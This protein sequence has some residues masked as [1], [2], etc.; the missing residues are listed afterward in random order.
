[1]G[2]LTLYAIK[3]SLTLA[4]LYLPYT[5]LMRRDTLFGFNR[6]A[7]IAIVG[8]SLVV[9]CLDLHIWDNSAIGLLEPQQET[10]RQITLPTFVV[11][12]PHSFPDEGE[13]A[14]QLL[15]VMEKAGRWLVLLYITGMLACL[16]WK[17]VGLVCL[18][19]FIPR[20]CLWI[21]EREDGIT[22]YCHAGQVAPFSWMHSIVIGEEHAAQGAV[23]EHELAHVRMGH[24]WDIVL[25]SL[26]ETLQWFNPCVWMLEASLREIHEYEADDA[27]LRRGVT[28]RDYQLLLIETAV[29]R[30]RYALVNSFNHSLLKN[31]IT[32]M[33]KQKT[34][35]W[36]RLK[37]LY[38]VPLTLIAIGAFASGKIE[39]KVEPL[40]FINKKEVTKTA[41]KQLD[42]K[43][44]DRIDVLG[45]KSAEKIYGEKGKD[46]AVLIETKKALQNP[47]KEVAADGKDVIHVKKGSL[48]LIVDGKEMTEQE[49]MKA[50]QGKEI[51]N[52]VSTESNG[53]V[54]LTTK[55]AEPDDKVYDTPEVLPEYPGGMQEF[56]NW[57]SKNLRYPKEAQEYGIDGRI[58][59]EFV[60]EK[61][62][63][64]T[65]IKEIAGPN[66]AEIVVNAYKAKDDSP[67]EVTKEKKDK[68]RKALQ[69]EAIR[70][71]KS[72][73]K[74]TPGREKGKA[75]RTK[76]VLPLIFRLS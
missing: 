65:H 6:T 45:P 10:L 46:G 54:V 63:S 55:T 31:R 67:E 8:L 60:V 1:M 41:V 47:E 28:A 70:A 37:V 62:G 29:D 49:A 25:V 53:T 57:M 33:T 38:A 23:L 19:R 50:V 34:S 18:I 76:F 22:L 9:P 32:M 27:V 16:L 71:V 72:M 75:V 48:R 64:I 24:S 4:L 51:E 66:G 59:V 30:S 69:E 44:I 12:T 15:P 73:P 61:D 68:G 20:G 43:A 56:R 13:V 26:M 11:G 36:A 74:W 42:P 3:S 17:A 5:L 52:A 14:P 21:D 39:E 40:T 2:T 35:P 7:L 58:T